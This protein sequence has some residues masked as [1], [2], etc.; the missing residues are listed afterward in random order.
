MKQQWRK[1][2]PDKWKAW[3][4]QDRLKKYG[5]DEQGYYALL[6]FQDDS[7]AICR[8]PF[9]STP[10]IDHDHG[11]GEVRGLLCANCNT[12]LGKLRDCPVVVGRALQYLNERK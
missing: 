3:R 2:H 6:W 5:L 9:V 7:C 10:H 12:A 1:K 4:E 11:S 8:A